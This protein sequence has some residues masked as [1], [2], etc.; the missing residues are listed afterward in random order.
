MANPFPAVVNTVGTLAAGHIVLATEWNAA[1]NG[2]YGYI[3]DTLLTTGLNKMTAKGDMYAFDGAAMQVVSTGGAAND[4]KLLVADSTVAVGV[5]F[6]SVANVT[7]LTTKGDLLG[8]STANTRI[9]VGTDGYLLTARSSN[10]N[11]VAWEAPPGIPIGGIIMWSQASGLIPSGYNICDGGTY[12]GVVTPNM[13][14]VFPVGAGTGTNP[15]AASGLGT[16]AVGAVGG[17][18]SHIHGISVSTGFATSGA[19]A[20]VS[21]VNPT[22]AGDN[23]PR[24]NAVF[25]IMRTI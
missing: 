3:N 17:A 16:L 9:P 15:P 4:G 14:G 8:Y 19:V 10:A 5:R 6:G 1:V 23:V 7:N 22:G 12:N 25:F 20:F 24:Y 13:Q 2:L 18:N 11:G 21:G